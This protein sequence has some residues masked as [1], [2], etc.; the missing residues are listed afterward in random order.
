MAEDAGYFVDWNGQTRSTADPGGGYICEVDTASRYVA[1]LTKTG[2]LV[3]EATFYRSFEA[4]EKAGI[5]APLVPGAT[6]W[7]RASE[8]F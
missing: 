2:A 1:I 8:G 3:H 4:V 6:P 5:K 7:G